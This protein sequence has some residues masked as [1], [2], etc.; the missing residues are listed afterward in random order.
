MFPDCTLPLPASNLRGQILIQ[1]RVEGA[2][3]WSFNV[4]NSRWKEGF[5]VK[6][7]S[8]GTQGADFP[9]VGHGPFAAPSMPPPDLFGFLP[10]L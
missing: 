5:G 2:C 3:S 1:P 4:S 6:L 7:V 10:A 9:V 8:E